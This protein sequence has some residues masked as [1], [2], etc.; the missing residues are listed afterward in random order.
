M[1]IICLATDLYL[2]EETACFFVKQLVN[3]IVLSLSYQGN[4]IGY[5]L[6]I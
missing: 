1:N 2:G 5:R 4:L 6:E 3:D